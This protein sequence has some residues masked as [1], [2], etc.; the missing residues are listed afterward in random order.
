M[1]SHAASMIDRQQE[2]SRAEVKYLTL[3]RKPDALLGIQFERAVPVLN[4]S[5]LTLYVPHGS[6]LKQVQD[7]MVKSKWGHHYDSWLKSSGQYHVDRG[8]IRP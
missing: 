4:R 3:T 6:T 1:K 2:V 7:F 8:S 5:C